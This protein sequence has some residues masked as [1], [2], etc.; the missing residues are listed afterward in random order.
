VISASGLTPLLDVLAESRRWLS[1][2]GNDYTWSSWRDRE[3]AVGELDALVARVRAGGELPV[4]GIDVLFLPTGPMQEVA[5]S[6][7][8]GDEFVD[9]ANR[10]DVALVEEPARFACSSCHTIAGTVALAG[11][12][13]V[14]RSFTSTLTQPVGD[15]LRAALAEALPKRDAAALH[16]LDLEFAPFW[17]PECSAS[18]CGRHWQH[19]TVVDGDGWPDSIRGRCPRGHERMLED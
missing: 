8:W 16:A 3:H 17:C 7:G 15:A 11:D 6:S 14:R 9:L 13:L 18:Y 10:V 5:L 2:P 1:L 4:W 19:W 12:T